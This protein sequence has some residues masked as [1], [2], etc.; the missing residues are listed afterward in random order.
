VLT[1]R[2]T[3]RSKQRQ[4]GTKVGSHA[5]TT[6]GPWVSSYLL[7]PEAF[8]PAWSRELDPKAGLARAGFFLDGR[9][10]VTQGAF[11]PATHHWLT[12][13]DFA[14]IDSSTLGVFQE[15]T[16]QKEDCPSW[17]A[18]VRA[19]TDG[20][21]QWSENDHEDREL[22]PERP[23]LIHRSD[24]TLD[25]SEVAGN[26]I[27]VEGP[28]RWQFAHLQKG[29]VTRVRGDAVKK[30]EVIGRVGS[31]GFAGSPHL[32]LT[33]DRTWR[34]GSEHLFLVLEDVFVGLNAGE[35][36]PWEVRLPAWRVESGYFV[37]S[38]AG[39]K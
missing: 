6:S 5:R 31:S 11:E 32:H 13:Y 21:V 39:A 30:G 4:A 7:T 18:E 33:T 37:R 29:S 12:A 10:F 38:A 17:G 27:E 34:T 16:P 20:V 22:D 28:F 35:D 26:R 3:L 2:T 1:I 36:D 8:E 14:R 19:P 23:L 25:P 9:W 15:P 24:L